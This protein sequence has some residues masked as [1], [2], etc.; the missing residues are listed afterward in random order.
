MKAARI[1]AWRPADP[2]FARWCELYHRMPSSYT[3][4]LLRL[5][6]LGYKDIQAREQSTH[7]QPS[8]APSNIGKPVITINGNDDREGA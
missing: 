4:A 1:V 5:M 3:A 8:T 2:K 6:E 7:P